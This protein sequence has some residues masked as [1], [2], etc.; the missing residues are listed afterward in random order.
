MSGCPCSALRPQR[1]VY[2]PATRLRLLRARC[3]REYVPTNCRRPL[4]G[5]TERLRPRAWKGRPTLVNGQETF[6]KLKNRYTKGFWYVLP[7]RRP[8]LFGFQVQSAAQSVCRASFRTLLPSRFHSAHA[9]AFLCHRLVAER[10]PLFV[11]LATTVCHETIFGKHSVSPS[12]TVTWLSH[13]YR[14]LDRKSVTV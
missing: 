3:F 8:A 9:T 6:E 10:L 2:H 5:T 11:T 12:P 1:L 13:A 4:T 14:Y 7:G